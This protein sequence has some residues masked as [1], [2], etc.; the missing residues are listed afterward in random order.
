MELVPRLMADIDRFFSAY[1]REVR[2]LGEDVKRFWRSNIATGQ[3]LIG[4]LERFYQHSE[5]EYYE[6][7]ADIRRF[8]AYGSIEWSRLKDRVKRFATCA[9]DPVFGDNIIPSEGD[10]NPGVLNDY[11]PPR[12]ESFIR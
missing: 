12:S 3:L 10:H 1:E 7:H 4:D 9:H 5:E 6:L 2:P 11:S 8:V